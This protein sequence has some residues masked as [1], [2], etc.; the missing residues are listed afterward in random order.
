M[1]SVYG[2]LKEALR[3][4]YL[5]PAQRIGADVTAAILAVARQDGDVARACRLASRDG[6]GNDVA[7]AALLV[8]YEELCRQLV[9]CGVDPLRRRAAVALMLAHQG[10]GD[11]R[12]A[13]DEQWVEREGNERRGVDGWS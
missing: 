5:G 6:A 13:T 12:Q 10:A 11:R 4:G 1:K 8:T 2:L 3:E 7:A 9:L